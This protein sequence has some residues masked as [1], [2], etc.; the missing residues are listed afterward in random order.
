MYDYSLEDSATTSTSVRHQPSIS[1]VVRFDAENAKLD[2]F[3]LPVYSEC[4]GKLMLN[5]G[6]NYI[7]RG[8]SP[9]LDHI[10]LNCDSLAIERVN[11]LLTGKSLKNKRLTKKERK[12]MKEEEEDEER[13]DESSE[14]FVR[15][16]PYLLPMMTLEDSATHNWDH[17]SSD[18]INGGNELE[19]DDY[20]DTLIF[21]DETDSLIQDIEDLTA[22]ALKETG[23]N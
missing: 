1:T 4:N 9:L 22:R 6:V 18:V 8:E 21:N 2:N 15:T 5:Y 16:E 7:N 14:P 10:L 11:P 19:W 12:R 23:L 17:E 13:N 20:Q 3:K